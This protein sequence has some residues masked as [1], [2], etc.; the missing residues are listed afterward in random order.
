MLHH[1]FPVIT[2]YHSR[3]LSVFPLM[4]GVR[5]LFSYIIDYIYIQY[6]TDSCFCS[7]ALNKSM[8][9]SYNSSKNSKVFQ[10]GKVKMF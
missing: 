5:I 7:L 8:T 9:I 4:A 2:I 3:L 10:E 6:S 1:K